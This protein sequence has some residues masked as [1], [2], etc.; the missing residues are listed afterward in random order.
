MKSDII[1]LIHIANACTRINEYITGYSLDD[2]MKL[3]EKQDAVI[4]QI[5]I[6]GEAASHITPECKERY[7]TISWRDIIGMRNMLIHQYFGV[8]LVE[9]YQTA[10]VDIPALFVAISNILHAEQTEDGK[11]I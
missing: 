8:D 10:T 2:F 1:L 5:E 9:T 4:R 6:V 7:S 3:P 11:I